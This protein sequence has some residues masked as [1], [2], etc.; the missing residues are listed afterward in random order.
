MVVDEQLTKSQKVITDIKFMSRELARRGRYVKELH[1][2]EIDC[3]RATTIF[4]AKE[5]RVKADELSR[6]YE[7]VE[8]KIS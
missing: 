4:D 1:A 8:K 3:L 7:A 6:R 2:I 5:L